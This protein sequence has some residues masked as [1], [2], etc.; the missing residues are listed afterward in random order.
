MKKIHSAT[1]NAR[2]FTNVTHKKKIP[3]MKRQHPISAKIDIITYAWL[4]RESQVSGVPKNRII[5]QAISM[6]IKLLD[7]R[8]RLKC[9]PHTKE[10]VEKL[11]ASI[12]GLDSM[13]MF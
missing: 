2:T 8:R 13:P 3:T 4:V 10:D 9:I 12:L 6:Y 11:S 5:N 1:Y 7:T